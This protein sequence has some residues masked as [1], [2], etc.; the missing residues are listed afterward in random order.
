MEWKLTCEEVPN[1]GEQVLCFQDFGGAGEIKCVFARYV[2]ETWVSRGPKFAQK[3]H[4]T[5]WIRLNPPPPP[6]P[7]LPE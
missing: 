4:F 1:E 2:E 3:G 6:P 5:H 7:P